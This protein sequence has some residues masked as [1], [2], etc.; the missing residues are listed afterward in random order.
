VTPV[1]EAVVK[2]KKKPVIHKFA[3]SGY[4]QKILRDFGNLDFALMELKESF[5]V[6]YFPILIFFC[7]V[8]SFY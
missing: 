4:P 1:L 3:S 2:G 5:L 6:H 8:S 7:K